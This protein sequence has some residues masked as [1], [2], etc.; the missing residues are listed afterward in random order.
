MNEATILQV[1][2][3]PSDKAVIA[4]LLAPVEGKT[5]V[6]RRPRGAGRIF[7]R[8]GKWWIAYYVKKE[9]RSVEMRESAG[10]TETE[11]RR[12]MKRRQDELAAH[13]LGVRSF[14]GPQQERVTVLQLL[15]E[16][17]R[18]YELRDLA[19]LRRL[20]SH[21]KHIKAFF[22]NDRALEV[23]AN[24]IS[25]YME[26]RQR[27]GAAN[28]TINRE[29][30]G[31]QR[32]FTL[33]KEQDLLSYIPHFQS[34]PEHN[35]RQGFFE[36]ADFEAILPRLSMRGKP[37]TDLQDYLSWCFFTG[38]RTG[39]TKALTWADLDRESW[40]IRLHAKDSKNR[41]GRAIPLENELRAIVERRL[42]ARR[43]DCPYIFHRHGVQ[44][45]DFRKVW[46]RAC[47]EAGLVKRIHDEETG[48]IRTVFPIPHDFRRSA[49]R[50]MVRAGVNPDIARQI[51]GH[52][53]P[54]IF[55]RYNI[56]SEVDLRQA[57]QRTS[58]YLATCPAK[59]NLAVLKPTHE[60]AG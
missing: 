7:Q 48:M 8:G 24:R 47:K 53:T 11:A 46:K 18:H 19:S 54:A 34:L 42:S 29:T 56:I 25:T 49:V 45:G 59:S 27:E 40:T 33:A 50:N 14:R 3:R 23:T 17:E 55:S 9:G 36:R 57:V 58:N 4:S 22:G 32:A 43:M 13:R 12:L 26:M 20:K 52:R 1:D 21:L 31:L 16:L 51:S 15:T 39:E 28:A 41:K 10:D 30:E 60:S 44:M 37:D 38:M 2:E 35:A 6:P 5:K